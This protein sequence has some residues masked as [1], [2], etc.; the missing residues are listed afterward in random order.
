MAVPA[1]RPENPNQS[2]LDLRL[3]PEKT[4]I[5]KGERHPQDPSGA[6]DLLGK[7]S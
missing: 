4:G 2:E 1:L 3:G 7:D 6:R 5:R